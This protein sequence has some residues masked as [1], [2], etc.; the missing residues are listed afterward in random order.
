MKV[1]SN[2]VDVDELIESLQNLP[3]G[4][5]VCVVKSEGCSEMGYVKLE[6]PKIHKVTG[7]IRVY[8]IGCSVNNVWTK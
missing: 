3:K 4:S 2:S 6:N 1:L 8:S 5:R 7:S